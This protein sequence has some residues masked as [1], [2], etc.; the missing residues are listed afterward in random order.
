MLTAELIRARLYRGEVRPR[1]IDAGDP[2]HLELARQLIATF[3]DHLGRTRGELEAELKEILG[4]GTAFL[5]HRGLAKLL[6][7]R[8][9][10]ETAAP[11]EPP[12]V[13]RAVFEAAA[14]AY[15]APHDP[16]DPRPFHFSRSGVL[17]EAAGSLGVT[18]EELE[19]GLYA[20]LKEEQVLTALEPVSGEWLLARYNVALAQAVLLR[21]T[22]LVIRLG[23]QSPRRHR[24]L[25]RKIKFFQLLHRVEADGQGGYAIHLDGPLSL[26][27]SSQKYGLKMASFLPTLLHFEAWSL[28][29]RLLWGRRRRQCTFRLSPAVGLTPYGHLTGQ[30]QPEE[31]TWLPEQF[32]KLESPW[33]V[34]TDGALVDLGGQGVL[35]P[36]FAF[37]HRESGFTVYMEVLGFW[38][39]G[40]VAGRLKL[41]RHHGPANLLLALSKQLAAGRDELDELPGEVYVFRQAPVARQVLAALERLRSKSE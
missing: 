40:A 39:K 32:S 22:E 19:R 13:R 11:A 26:F 33:E 29:A 23:P 4:T 37:R 28:E 6:A 30:W 14:A 10:F 34:S 21:A 17:E 35:V 1:Y 38:N 5:L 15:R 3:E 18:T 27:Q 36:D 9:T 31:L 24:A 41:L 7:D 20:D 25:F 2:A 12:E 16:E 8:C